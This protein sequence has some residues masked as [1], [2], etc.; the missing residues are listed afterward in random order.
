M[1]DPNIRDT[2]VTER[3]AAGLARQAIRD[4]RDRVAQIR[5]RLAD[6]GHRRFSTSKGVT[7][8]ARD[9]QRLLEPLAFHSVSASFKRKGVYQVWVLPEVASIHGTE[10]LAIEVDVYAVNLD[11]FQPAEPRSLGFIHPHALARMFL[12]LQTTAF[13]AVREQ[14]RSSLYMYAAL[15]EAC[16]AQRL[17]QIVIPTRDGYFRCDVRADVTQPCALIAKTWIAHAACGRRDLGVLESIVNALS[18][19]NDRA[20]PAEQ[21]QIAILMKSPETMV[22]SLVEA[23]RAHQWLAEPY[24][25]RPDHLSEIWEAARRQAQ[26]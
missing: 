24:Q 5:A 4:W 15:A 18:A 16:R 6:L 2:F 19:W 20:S 3:L 14:I 13:A 21:H 22:Q 8:V 17:F 1:V 23:L 9:T 7:R 10:H 25:E 11:G 12:R 26:E